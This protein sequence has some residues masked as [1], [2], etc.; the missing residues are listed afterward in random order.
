M[1]P[2]DYLLLHPKTLGLT[3][4]FLLAL[5]PHLPIGFAENAWE[6]GEKWARD[7]GPLRNS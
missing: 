5:D 2:I 7:L 4:I 1:Y 3:P 6:P